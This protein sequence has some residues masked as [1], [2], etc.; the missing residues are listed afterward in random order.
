M[1]PYPIWIRQGIRIQ[2][3]FV[4]G[5]HLFDYVMADFL[6]IDSHPG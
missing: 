3:A 5:N 1:G 4:D 6:G 2:F